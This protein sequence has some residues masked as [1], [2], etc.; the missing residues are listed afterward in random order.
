[1]PTPAIQKKVCLLGDFA[2]GKTSL[3]RRFVEGIFEDKYL[4][5]IGTKVSRRVITLERAGRPVALTMLIWDLAGGEKFDRVM[6]SYYRGAAGAILVCDLTRPETLEALPGY[7]GDFWK[8]NPRVPL[9]LLGNKVDLAD[10]RAV[11]DRDLATVAGQCQ[12]PWFTSS[13]KTGENVEMAFL[14][15]GER[16]LEAGGI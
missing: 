5:T 11:S 12:A 16:M 14:L 10:Q 6:E 7:A 9:I 15:L 8:V 2:V 4:S 13:A 1:M 3:V